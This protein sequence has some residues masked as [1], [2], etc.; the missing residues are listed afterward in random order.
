MNDF[1]VDRRQVLSAV[2]LLM[3]LAVGTCAANGLAAPL[4]D[5][6]RMRLPPT[7]TKVWV[8]D[9]GNSRWCRVAR[10][11]ELPEALTFRSLD[12]YDP[13]GQLNPNDGG[14]WAIDEPVLQTIFAGAIE[15]KADASKPIQD[16]LDGAARLGRV[17]DDKDALYRVDRSITLPKGVEWRNVQ[18]RAGTQGMNVVRISSDSKFLDFR[19]V[20]TGTV[21][22]RAAT[23]SEVHER[24]I[25]PASNSLKNAVV[26]GHISRITVGVHLQP[27]TASGIPPTNC[28]IDVELT[29]IVGRPDMSEGYGVLLSPALGCRVR[30]KARNIQRHAVYLSAGASYNIVDADVTDCFQDAVTIF[31]V[32]HQPACNGNELTVNARG[33][34]VPSGKPVTSNSACFSIYGKANDNVAVVSAD[35]TGQGGGTA[36]YAAVL[37]HGMQGAAGP[38]PH[39]NRVTVNVRGLFGGPYA[40]Q[41]ID[42]VE[43]E[44]AGGQIVGRGT[45][46]VI[47]FSDTRQNTAQFSRAGKVSQ[48]YIDGIDG[49]GFGVVVATE[50]SNVEIMSD[51]SFVRVKK[52]FRDYTGRARKI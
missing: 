46:G 31:S 38:F 25:Y 51:V 36:A 8:T 18:L 49:R 26:R 30:V 21:S 17:V 32:A 43:T 7:M 44:I 1:R 34:R 10:K 15:A 29:E 6:Q 52:K 35:A 48:L 28:T 50:R 37:V 47:G 41:C 27:L 11:P 19:I 9:R 23:A 42:A 16:T 20:G 2:K 14:W 22:S 13:D 5:Y 33:V 45:V 40:V 4:E 3:A 39:G 24:A 12:R